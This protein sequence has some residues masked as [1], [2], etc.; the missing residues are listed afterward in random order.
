MY[1][2]YSVYNNQ[3]YF[4]WQIEKEISLY[5]KIWEENKREMRFK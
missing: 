3:G 5:L 4:Q 1:L 2:V